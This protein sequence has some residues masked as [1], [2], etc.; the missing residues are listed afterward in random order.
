MFSTFLVYWLPII[1]TFILL[2]WMRYFCKKR[3]DGSNFPTIGHIIIVTA[4]TFIPIFGIIVSLFVL[5]FYIAWRV[6]G[7]LEL[8]P[9]KFNRFFFDVG[10]KNE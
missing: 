9:N 3:Y 7:D 5:G 4:A 6:E 1:V 8:K 2:I 10:K